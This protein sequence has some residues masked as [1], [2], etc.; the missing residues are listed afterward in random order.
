MITNWQNGAFFNMKIN[1]SSTYLV[2]VNHCTLLALVFSTIWY[3][4]CWDHVKTDRFID[5]WPFD[6]LQITPILTH[7]KPFFLFNLGDVQIIYWPCYSTNFAAQLIVKL[8]C[9]EADCNDQMYSLP[10]NAL[11]ETYTSRFSESWYSETWNCK[12]KQV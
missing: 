1:F 7:L 9:I 2:D 5:I 8:M 3:Q 4:I 10:S 12:Y 11:A 6:I